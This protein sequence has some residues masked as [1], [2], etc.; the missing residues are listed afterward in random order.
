MKFKRRKIKRGRVEIIPMIDTI[1]ILLIFYM[2][3]SRLA[4][5]EREGKVDLPTSVT[6]EESKGV[7]GHLTVNMYSA[8]DISIQGVHY[9]A[10]QLSAVLADNRR[11]EPQ[12]RVLLRGSREMSFKDLSVLLN[13][14]STAQ[15]RDVAFATFEA[16]Q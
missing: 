13:A 7:A 9:Q 12:L 5:M 4:Q 8:N 14:C 16:R 6:G 15:I 2:S 10:A 3:F 1:V 11:K